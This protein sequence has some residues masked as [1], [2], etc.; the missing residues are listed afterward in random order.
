MSERFDRVGVL[1]EAEMARLGVPGVALGVLDGGLGEVRGFGVNNREHPLPVDGRTLFRIASISKTFVAMAILRL[2]EAGVL[3][4]DRPIKRYLPDFRLRDL[5]AQENAT[6]RHCLQHTGGWRGDVF[7]DPQDPASSGRGNDAL[8]RYVAGLAH[9]P[10][11]TSLGTVWSY[12]NAGFGIAGRVLEVTSGRPF[13]SAIEDLL[14]EP[15]GMRH[16]FFFAERLVTHRVAAGHV[17]LPDGIYVTRP[18]DIGRAGHP[19]GGMISC[20]EDLLTWARFILG[21]GRAAAG[22]RL[23]KRETID[24]ALA[25]LAPAGSLADAIGLAWQTTDVGGVRTVGHG[26]VWLNQMSSLRLAP[27]L[28]FAVVCLTNGNR[29]TELHGAVTGRALEEYLG[30]RATESAPLAMSADALAD[31]TGTYTAALDDVRLDL[32]A[33]E[34]VLSVA[35]RERLFG[36]TPDAPMSAPT[37]LVFRAPDRVVGRDEPFK[38]ARGEFLRDARGEITWFRWGGRIHARV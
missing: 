4:L 20:V 9:A 5:E 1:V 17:A 35:R 37:R 10:Q 2:V 3:D 28:G 6:L 22:V 16:T 7:D 32:V 38:G 12:N 23:L 36:I 15:L 34:L 31:F 33:G 29:G 14:L 11:L 18:W 24:H 13:E 21:D 8:A 25:P 30:A 27:D 19:L 26:G